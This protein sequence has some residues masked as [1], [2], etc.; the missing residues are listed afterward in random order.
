MF[1]IIDIKFKYPINYGLIFL[2]SFSTLFFSD[3][4]FMILVCLSVFVLFQFHFSFK[5]E[6][7]LTIPLIS[8]MI[9]HQ[10]FIFNIVNY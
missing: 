9:H 2:L 6:C 5:V 4:D 10:I 3:Q 1:F 7:H 8:Q